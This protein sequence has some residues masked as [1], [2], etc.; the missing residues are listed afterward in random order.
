MKLRKSIL[1]ALAAFGLAAGVTT[2]SA[3]PAAANDIRVFTTSV[4]CPTPD[5]SDT[6]GVFRIYVRWLRDLTVNPDK[7]R[8]LFFM[9][10]NRYNHT[11]EVRHFG[12]FDE[13]GSQNWYRTGN[14]FVL[15]VPEPDGSHQAFNLWYGDTGWDYQNRAPDP[16]EVSD[17]TALPIEATSTLNKVYRG[18]N[19]YTSQNDTLVSS[20]TNN[21]QPWWTALEND[22][23][24]FLVTFYVQG[25]VA[26]C[27]GWYPP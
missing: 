15:T 16:G 10:Q 24:Y 13:P 7:V 3:T 23:P 25:D 18:P 17:P 19:K 12:H 21:A 2:I 6:S 27:G 4:D 22:S 8:P 20:F 5:T 9:F 11:S 26:T 1:A 14:P